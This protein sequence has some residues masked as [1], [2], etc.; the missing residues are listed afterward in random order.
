MTAVT[1]SSR[2]RRSF[3]DLPLFAK[4]LIP[5]IT[6]LLL[7]GAAG[8]LLITRELSSRAETAVNQSLLQ[9]SLRAR[10]LFQNRELYVLESA[11]LAANIEG[12]AESIDDRAP[13]RTTRLLESVLALKS[14]LNLLAVVRADGS[15]IVEFLR[16]ASGSRA[17][18]ASH[19][20][21]AK[22]EL[23]RAALRT[24]RG[25]RTAGFSELDGRRLLAVVGPIC[26]RGLECSPAGV[27]V[28]G[29]WLDELARSL[30]QPSSPGSAVGVAF[31]ENGGTLLAGSGQTLKGPAAAKPTGTNLIRRT[32]RVD[33]E[34]VATMFA[35]L[36][37]A[38]RPEGIMAVTL[39]TGPITTPLRATGIQLGLILVAALGGLIVIG[40]AISRSA[41]G[42]VRPLLQNSR[43]LG[44]GELSARTPVLGNDELGELARHF[45]EMAGQL[46]ASHENL[47]SLVAQRTEEI[48]R[49][50][51][52]RTEFFASI[53]HEL[54]TPLAVILSR[55]KMM[56][57]P[58]YRRAPRDRH[59]AL[60]TIKES[61]E[62]LLTLVNEIL[63]LARIEA[64]RIE[65]NIE[66]VSI[67]ELIAQMRDT[68]VGLASARDIAVDI[69]LFD[70]PLVRADP[71]RLREILL[72]I[73]DNAVKYT[74]AG[75]RT[76]LSARHVNDQVEM[77]V[78]DT[79]VGLPDSVG[80]LIFEPFY[81]VPGIQTQHGEAASGL[82]LA[83]AK[84][85]VEAQ[86][87][88]ISYQQRPEGGSTFIV[89]LP[90]AM[91]TSGTS[92]RRARGDDPRERVRDRAL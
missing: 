79:G 40:L 52:G 60:H 55:V 9:A 14:E 12:M 88:S 21:W 82:G 44:R 35:G 18:R 41:L 16:R 89:R 32:G 25:E 92:V 33:G 20:G 43:A 80:D 4:L 53:S 64:G 30:G 66:D 57:N 59:E 91:R 54:R 7:A 29:V 78:S 51:R 69:G 45:N 26:R 39:A 68:I 86:D 77:V 63:D 19:S 24:T 62:E 61:G 75:G 47:E 56:L 81:R 48:E 36:D 90:V 42:Q 72:N 49:L 73:V 85:L 2:L 38:G 23:V 8:G 11:T 67:E 17:T 3:R 28:A 83:L 76:E 46:Q 13:T 6:I 70:V 84:R 27:V 65:L 58:T 1:Q 71:R 37:I 10:A 22:E 87:G 31:Y 34:E 50:L 5:S 74:P 15:S